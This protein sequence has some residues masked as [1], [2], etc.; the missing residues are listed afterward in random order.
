MELTARGII[1]KQVPANSDAKQARAFVRELAETIAPVVRPSVILDCSLVR[2]IDSE[3]LYLLLCCLEEA[4]K[5][6]GDVRLAGVPQAAQP[7]L[8]SL[9]MERLFRFYPS[10]AQA[11]E[12]FRRSA[13]VTTIY[14]PSQGST[15]QP[16]ARA[17]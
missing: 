11:A 2:R 8:Q 14:A 1:V 5:R 16:S 7:A 4:M 10:V 15:A 6:N 12:S 17:A 9:G 3:F 13:P